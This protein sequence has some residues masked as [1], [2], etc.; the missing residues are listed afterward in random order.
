MANKQKIVV[1]SLGGS[2]IVPE[3][4]DYDFLK[5]FK[6]TIHTLKGYKIVICTGGGK[7]ARNYID[8]LKKGGLNDYAQDLMGIDVT[9]LNAKLVASFL[10]NCNQNI[11]TTLEEIAKLL[12]SNNIVVCG[13]L[14]PGRTS[15]GTT[16][17]IAEYLK[18]PMFINITNV[19]G[20]FDKDPKKFKDAKL[21][22]KISH[23]EFEKII[24]KVKEGPGQHFVLDSFAAK[25]ARKSKIRIIILKGTD[26]LKKCL[27]EKEFVGTIIS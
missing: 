4:V 20:L 26:N 5:K 13:G 9:R 6:E 15:D 12:E 17:E 25:T 19:D 7:T 24:S 11:P 18:A 2:I 27:E 14:S 10:Q 1:I 16:A 23:E 21:I 3:N 8:T 22:Q